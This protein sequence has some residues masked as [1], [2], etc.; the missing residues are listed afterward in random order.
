MQINLE[1][2]EK[3]TIEGYSEQEIRVNAASYRQNLIVSNT[4]I[5]TDWRIVSIEQLSEDLLLPLLQ[6]NAEII[7]IGHNKINAF[8]P[9]AIMQVLSQRRI[10]MESMPIGAACRTFNILLGEKRNVALGIIF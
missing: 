5:L 9:P 3:Y 10:A 8:P 4:A 6:D 2:K 7:I 1:A